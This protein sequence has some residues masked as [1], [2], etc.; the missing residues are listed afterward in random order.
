MNPSF[1]K[2]HLISSN[3]HSTW[4]FKTNIFID[5]IK[6]HTES[7][8]GIG[9]DLAVLFATVAKWWWYNNQTF[10]TDFHTC[11]TLIPPFDDFTF[12][13]MEFKLNVDRCERRGTRVTVDPTGAPFVLLSKIFPPV[14]LP[15]Y[16]EKV[17][18]T[19][20]RNVH[21]IIPTSLRL[22]YQ[23]S[24]PSQSQFWHL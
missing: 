1:E 20:T 24:L 10:A 14:S 5:C 11:N 6:A 13:Q 19:E 23:P 8:S 21:T 9:R 4:Y 22:Y 12:T 2:T 7:K 15:I 3:L 18:R 17:L 16:L